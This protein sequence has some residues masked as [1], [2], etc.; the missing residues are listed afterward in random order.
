METRK[1]GLFCLVAGFV[2]LGIVDTNLAKRWEEIYIPPYDGK[3]EWTNSF[4]GTAT[5]GANSQSG[6]MGTYAD[7][8]IG[9][10][11][12]AAWQRIDFQV[13]FPSS[14]RATIKVKYMGNAWNEGFAGFS[15]A[16]WQW[17]VNANGSEHRSDIFPVFTFEDLAGKIVDIVCLAGEFLP[18]GTSLAKAIEALDE[19]KLYWDLAEALDTAIQIGEAQALT[20]SFCFTADPGWHSLYVGIR[21]DASG[22]LTGAGFSVLAAQ[23]SEV[24]LLISDGRQDLPDLTIQHIDLV[25]EDKL[26]IGQRV[27]FNVGISN[28]GEADAETCDLSFLV[29]TP[30]VPD[31]TP[32]QGVSQNYQTF[33]PHTTHIYGFDYFFDKKGY[34]GFRTMVDPGNLVREMDE[35]NNS[36]TRYYYVKGRPPRK[37]AAPS[38]PMPKLL[39]RNNTYAISSSTTDPDG[40]MLQYQFQIRRKGDTRHYYNPWGWG[41]TGRVYFTPT[42]DDAIQSGEAGLYHVRVQAIDSDGLLSPWSDETEFEVASNR[43]PLSPEINGP[44]YGY[45]ADTLF[46]TASATDPEGDRLGYW[47]QWGDGEI[48][49]YGTEVGADSVTVSHNFKKPGKYIVQAKT[50]DDLGGESAWATSPVQTIVYAAPGSTISVFMNN[51]ANFTLTGPKTYKNSGPSWSTQAD[52]GK[53]TIT[54]DPIPYF[55]TPPSST[56]IL[57]KGETITFQGEYSH[58]TGTLQVLT[59]NP[60]ASFKVTGEGAATQGQ[61][62]VGYGRTGGPWPDTFAGNYT[63]WYDPYSGLCLPPT[64]G[65]TLTL[66]P[67]QLLTFNGRYLQPPADVLKVIMAGKFAIAGEKVALFDGSDSYDPETDLGIVKYHFDFGDG[68]S[69]EETANYAPDGTYDG[70]TWHVFLASGTYP[71]TLTVFDPYGNPG[72]YTQMVLVKSRPHGLGR[73]KPFP[74]ITGE[75]VTM[76]GTGT[77]A[78]GDAIVAYEWKSSL[79][80]LLSNLKNVSTNLLSKDVHRIDL[81]VQDSDGLWSFPTGD[82]MIVL[83]AASWPMFKQNS[84]RLSNQGPY[85][86]RV[87]GL[88]GY[89]S[90]WTFPTAGRI[91]GSPVAANLDGDWT[92]GLEIAFASTAGTLEVVSSDGKSLWSR[93][94]GIS[95]SSPTLADIDQDGNLDIVVGSGQ[96]VYAFDR[97]GNNLYTFNCPLHGMGFDSTSV[98]A[99]IDGDPNNGSETVIGCLDGNVYALSRHGIPIW[100]FRSPTGAFTSSPVVAEI[101]PDLPGPEIVIAGT[102]GI[103]YILDASGALITSFATPAPPV[104]AIETTPALAKLIPSTLGTEIV[105]GS[106]DGHLYCLTYHN[107]ILTLA[108]QYPVLG[109]PA[110]GPI[111]SSPAIGSVGEYSAAFQVIFGCDNGTIYVL[112]GSSGLCVGQFNCPV[113]TMIRSSPAVANLDT[114][115]NLH[116]TLG[117]LPEVIFGATDGNLYAIS[118]S[119]GFWGA[120]LPWSPLRI[121]QAPA[122]AIFSSP[123]VADINHDP[124]LEILIGADD[125]A[126]HVLAPSK[127]A[128]LVPVAHFIANPL[129]GNQPMM[130]NFTDQSSNTPYEWSWDFGDGSRSEQ[131]NPCHIYSE[132]GVYTISLTV[133][134]AHGCGSVTRKDCITVNPVPVADFTHSPAI[135]TV[136]LTVNFQDQSQYNSTTWSW[137]FGDSTTSNEQSPSHTYF[138]PGTYSVSLLASNVNGS[139][140]TRKN[141]CVIVRE[142]EPVADFTQDIQSGKVVLSV[143]FT[144]LSTGNP[145]SWLWNFGDGAIS[146]QKS[147]IHPYDEPGSYLVSLTVSNA[148]GSNTKTSSQLIIVDPQTDS[149][150]IPQVPDNDQPPEM[151]LDMN[152]SNFSAPMATANVTE[153]WDR[154]IQS[155][156][157]IL[158]NA[159]LPGRAVSEYIGL[160]TD[161]DGLGSLDRGNNWDLHLGTY[162]KDIAPGLLDFVRWDGVHSFESSLPWS[163]PL[164]DLK[165][166]YTWDAT[167][168][169]TPT[170]EQYKT[171]IDKGRPP[172]MVFSYW[173]PQPTGITLTNVPTAEKISI[174]TWGELIWSSTE[175]NPL[176]P[177]EQWNLQSDEY[178][179][180][181]AVTGVGYITNWDPDD[182]GPLPASDYVIV[183]DNW[184]TTPR[185]IAIPWQNW[186]ALVTIQAGYAADL[187]HDGYV[188]LEDFA[189]FAS[190]WQTRPMDESYNGLA[191]FNEDDFIDDTDLAVFASNWLAGIPRKVQKCAS[192]RRGSCPM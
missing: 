189:L 104:R 185:N 109:A 16:S 34:Y 43:D 172:I 96:G 167:T 52:P 40:D 134:N 107:R 53:Y 55:N 191:D 62:F 154:V 35:N 26:Q 30:S 163:V 187:N 95:N 126:L 69:Y 192:R 13:L 105:F 178:A 90:A 45:T 92:N 46:F 27:D 1:S 177:E 77:D 47:F 135:G 31:F 119:Q 175:A 99:E 71:V 136:P 151:I 97:K 133:T 110:L 180:G 9:G 12:S 171:E 125:G 6:A 5:A 20:E 170:W 56:K 106:D 84:T 67:G 162:S 122:Q 80:G 141:S 157:A 120:N 25:N 115:N 131:Q 112:Q 142:T 17:K 150:L 33:E 130:V 51:D 111:K 39:L 89:R 42:K 65:Q 7:G 173:N 14:I 48:N 152:S 128:V 127:N 93:N 164:P 2:V 108:W 159:G 86:G 23:L 81:T 8:W 186:I 15:G 66:K 82:A 76:E 168:D 11:S 102:D 174:Y 57:Y 18:A 155:S 153:F 21:S 85:W 29:S 24:R 188:N 143:H 87:H 59:N 44:A 166:G 79:D 160:Y 88:L 182:T 60:G 114:V 75:S 83:E 117:D 132:P 74:A 146:D 184:S 78:D 72:S 176:N 4:G 28:I 103:L 161:T 138:K 179:V 73:L 118:F 144:D 70:K 147:P 41:D 116:P 64:N 3:K 61:E 139:S 140:E 98:V 183:H 32:W 113:G 94:I 100:S 190:C 37:P 10:S 158:V 165:Q 129:T 137:D 19:V 181:H 36:M 169:Y 63:V 58:Q 123:A 148:S 124:D 38:V 121:A 149:V 54:F 156:Q 68:G 101:E 49:S 145:D 50:F 91:I 22:C